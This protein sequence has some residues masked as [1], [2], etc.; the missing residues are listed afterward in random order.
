MANSDNKYD[1]VFMKLVLFWIKVTVDE[2]PQYSYRYKALKVSVL[3]Q[4][5]LKNVNK[6]S[7]SVLCYSG[8][9]TGLSKPVPGL[10]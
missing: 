5:H 8:K 6:F 9:D 3:N 1:L 10:S 4:L 7:A 2:D